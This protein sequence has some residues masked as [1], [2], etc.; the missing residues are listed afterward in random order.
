MATVD[1]TPEQIRRMREALGLNQSEFAEKLG[2]SQPT[3]SMWEIGERSP[4]G[5]AAML[6]EMLSEKISKKIKNV[7]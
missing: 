1:Y 7:R 5:S 2:V 6:L 4:S 3:V